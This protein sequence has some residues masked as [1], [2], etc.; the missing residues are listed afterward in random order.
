[1][2]DP[3]VSIALQHGAPADVILHALA[4]RDVGPLAAALA[5]I[6]EAGELID[7]ADMPILADGPVGRRAANPLSLRTSSPL[8]R[9]SRHC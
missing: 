6:D 7:V 5:L 9:I 2:G 3:C 1:M 4:G 8:P